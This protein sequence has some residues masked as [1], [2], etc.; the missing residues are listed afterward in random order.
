MTADSDPA[1]V[2]KAAPPGYRYAGAWIRLVALIIDNW[3]L[4]AV[5][6]G[7][8]FVLRPVIPHYGPIDHG[9]NGWAASVVAYVLAACVYLGWFAGWQAA[10]GATP[11]MLLVG[12][13]VRGPSG[14]DKPSL[15]AAV[16]RNSLLVLAESV[17]TISR[18]T[19]I[20][21]VLG[22]AGLVLMVAI[23]V[24][25]SNSSTCQGIHDRLAG[26]TYV[27]RRAPAPTS[28]L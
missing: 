16:I 6:V 9:L 10:I 21:A 24:S 28:T 13:R 22:I 27:L 18:D 25:I 3:V 7:L 26:G 5:L 11:G 20:G 2:S 1:S 14:E 12:L 15:V 19:T 8:A 17:G 4:A 23:G